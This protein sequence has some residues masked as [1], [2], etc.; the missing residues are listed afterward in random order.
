MAKQRQD[1]VQSIRHGSM[2]TA[3]L[4]RW[5]DKLPASP[6]VDTLLLEVRSEG[7]WSRL[8]AWERSDVSAQLADTINETIQEYANEQGSFTTARVAWWDEKLEK[9]W[10]T[11]D[12]RVPPEMGD[13][14]DGGQAFSG[15]VQSTNIQ[16]QRHLEFMMRQHV[17]GVAVAMQALRQ[18]TETSNARVVELLEEV[19][20]LRHDNLELKEQLLKTEAALEAALERAESI[21]A[22]AEENEQ[23]SNV[24]ALVTKAL[25]N[26]QQQRQPG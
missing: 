25:T 10:T 12:L 18:T 2:R 24:V 20:Q 14:S 21:S 19:M 5:L 7:E 4:A 6:T 1:G 9:Y 22:E 17:G 8:Q 3:R 11:Y 16:T 23:Q 15:D 13:G 26:Q